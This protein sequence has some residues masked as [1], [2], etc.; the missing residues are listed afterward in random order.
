ME[1]VDIKLGFY[2][3]NLCK[4]CVQG[5]KRDFLP[6]KDK[7]EVIDSLREAY[8]KGKREVVFTGGEPSLHPN[9]LELVNMGIDKT[10][11]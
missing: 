5:R 6:A 9:F 4:F 8:D 7:Q 11:L 2:C 3:N 10:V 1:R